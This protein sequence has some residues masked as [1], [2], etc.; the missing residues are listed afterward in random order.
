VGVET[1][2]L[3]TCPRD[4]YDA[5][6]ILVTLRDG[7]I[8]SVRGD[9][10]HPVSRGKLCR[11]CSIG[12]NGV[13]LDPAERLTRPLRRVGPKGEAAFEPVGWDEAVELITGRWREIAGTSGAAAILNAHYTGTCSLIAKLTFTVSGRSARSRSRSKAG[14][15]A[16]LW[17]KP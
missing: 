1:T 3:T 10:D 2:L 16:R 15:L 13:F 14:C 6:G 12:Y 11:K 9:P 4:C 8:R 7:E 17:L 5:C